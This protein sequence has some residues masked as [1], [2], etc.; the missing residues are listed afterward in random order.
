MNFF[1][2]F[3]SQNTESLHFPFYQSRYFIL[4]MPMKEREVCISK[5]YK[6]KFQTPILALILLLSAPSLFNIY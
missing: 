4:G 1:F 3:F 6:A 5:L 2:T